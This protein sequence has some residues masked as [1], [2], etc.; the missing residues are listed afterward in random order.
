M[1]TKFQ[2]EWDDK[3]AERQQ[4]LSKCN[5]LAPWLKIPQTALE[6]EQA[7]MKKT[8]QQICE[9]RREK[10]AATEGERLRTKPHPAA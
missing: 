5:K 10:S 2:G 9:L 6:N 4:P 7:E 1:Q 8:Q 3:L